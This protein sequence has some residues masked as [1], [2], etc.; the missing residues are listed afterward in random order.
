MAIFD[1]PEFNIFKDEEKTITN[2]I[3]DKLSRLRVIIIGTYILYLFDNIMN[4]TIFL[5]FLYRKIELD[6]FGFHLWPFVLE[7]LLT[8]IIFLFIIGL[9]YERCC[10][11]SIVVENRYKYVHQK[12]IFEIIFIS[13]VLIISVFLGCGSLTMSSLG[14][15]RD[16]YKQIRDDNKTIIA[17]IILNIMV[18]FINFLFTFIYTLPIYF[19]VLYNYISLSKYKINH[20]E[21]NKKKDSNSV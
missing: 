18:G 12:S 21:S 16:D 7:S 14:L 17:F 4:T 19:Y 20:M 10:Q 13:V 9:F 11:S 6:G 3:E 8:T 2:E 5:Y 1:L 15:F